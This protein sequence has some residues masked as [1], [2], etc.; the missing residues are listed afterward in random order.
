MIEFSDAIVDAITQELVDL[1]AEYSLGDSVHTEG[2]EGFD[3]DCLDV[4]LLVWE[5][6][7]WYITAGDSSF[8]QEHGDVCGAAVLCGGEDYEQ[9][10]DIARDLLEQVLDN[11]M[12]ERET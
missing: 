2:F 6:G 11:W 7:R 1:E 9:C 10:E 12:M 5:D 3:A 4:R 8:D